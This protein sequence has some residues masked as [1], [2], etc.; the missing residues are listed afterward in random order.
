MH[1][2][3]TVK[4]EAITFVYFPFLVCNL[5]IIGVD[6]GTK[7]VHGYRSFCGIPQSLQETVDDYLSTAL[8]FPRRHL[9]NNK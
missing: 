1:K 7:I 6:L 4:V 9:T 2:G 3:H 8:I 5:D